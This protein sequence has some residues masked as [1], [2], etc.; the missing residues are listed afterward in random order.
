MSDQKELK[1]TSSSLVGL[2]AENAGLKQYQSLLNLEK[3][4]SIQ[5]DWRQALKENGKNVYA[6]DPDGTEKSHHRLDHDPIPSEKL[7]R[8]IDFFFSHIN[9]EQK[10]TRNMIETK[11]DRTSRGWGVMKEFII[12]KSEHSQRS[13]VY[14][15]LSKI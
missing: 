3:K 10:I 11:D 12:E 14:E 1:D 4:K 6:N 15:M 5:L 9:S 7:Q 13:R 8:R 2:D